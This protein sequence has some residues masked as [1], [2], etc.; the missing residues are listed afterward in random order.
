MQLV[1]ENSGQLICGGEKRMH[2]MV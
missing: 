1:I 2:N